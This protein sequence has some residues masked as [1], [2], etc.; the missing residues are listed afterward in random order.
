MKRPQ[1]V[2]KISELL[3]GIV[4]TA[5][6]ILYGS[7]ARGDAD[8]DSDIDI[9]IVH[10]NTDPELQRKITDRLLDIEIDNNICIS[11]YIVSDSWWN[12]K[13]LTPF[14]INVRNEGI[15]I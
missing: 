3:H 9:L 1:I 10:E 4:P 13:P 12:R 15:V 2:N 5:K 7:E 14:L 11:S 8:K 6:V